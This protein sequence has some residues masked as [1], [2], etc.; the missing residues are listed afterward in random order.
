MS[1]DARGE[2]ERLGTDAGEIMGKGYEASGKGRPGVWGVRFVTAAPGAQNQDLPLGGR[3]SPRAPFTSYLELY[4]EKRVSGL[5]PSRA[6]GVAAA[7]TTPVHTKRVVT[8][9][10]SCR[11]HLCAC[12]PIFPKILRPVPCSLPFPSHPRPCTQRWLRRCGLTPWAC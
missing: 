9:G 6:V 5:D 4:P 2:K 7:P 11:H 8:S 3:R 10:K 12:V 1:Y